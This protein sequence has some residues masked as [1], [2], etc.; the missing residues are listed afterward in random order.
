[1]SQLSEE[2]TKEA[3]NDRCGCSGSSGTSSDKVAG[4][5]TR[6]E[7]LISRW[8]ANKSL[9]RLRHDNRQLSQEAASQRKVNAERR[10]S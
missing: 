7:E 8:H 10:R 9:V 5:E 3:A 4:M 2:Q 1:M 6:Q